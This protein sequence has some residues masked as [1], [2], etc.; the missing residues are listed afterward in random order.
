M[1]DQA[2]MRSFRPKRSSPSPDGSTGALDNAA[3]AAARHKAAMAA[4]AIGWTPR[5]KH[6]LTGTAEGEM[7]ARPLSFGVWTFRPKVSTKAYVPPPP[8]PSFK[9][10]PP[11]KA[12]VVRASELADTASKLRAEAAALEKEASASK[13]ANARIQLG[14]MMLRSDDAVRQTVK[15]WCNGKDVKQAEFRLHVRNAG[16]NA[17]S[18]EADEMFDV[19]RPLATEPAR[20]PGSLTA[21]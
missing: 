13:K 16:I 19:F 6:I 8:P 10:P 4:R 20:L 11:P 18:A 2:S 3:A 7:R 15:Q 21:F 12:A 1:T 17:T 9:K 5:G 14:L